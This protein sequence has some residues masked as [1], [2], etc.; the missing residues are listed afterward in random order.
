MPVT[1]AVLDA[2][3]LYP[4]PL[5]DLFMHLAIVG[6][7]QARWTAD[8]HEEWTRNILANRPDLSRERLERTR[9]MMDANAEG[10]LVEGYEHLILGLTLPDPDDRHVLAAAIESEAE[11]IVTLNLRDFPTSVLTVYEITAQKPDDFLCTL[12]E[13]N[14]VEVCEAVRNQ[15][16]LLKNPPKTV[17]E[18]LATLKQNGL[19]H[20]VG[21]LS[22][23]LAEI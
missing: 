2:C 21:A 11:I 12:L 20:F 8:I 3:V 14:P 7:F 18:H 1:R 13:Q 10:S 9:A 19:S 5:R 16:N 4:A 23:H 6:A 22:V 15:R 17:E